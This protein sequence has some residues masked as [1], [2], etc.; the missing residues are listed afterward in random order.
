MT[1]RRL[2]SK[3]WS[4][5]SQMTRLPRQAGGHNIE[6]YHLKHK[7]HFYNLLRLLVSLTYEERLLTR[8]IT[9]FEPRTQKISE[10]ENGTGSRS[11]MVFILSARLCT[12]S[13]IDLTNYICSSTTCQDW[14]SV[15]RTPDYS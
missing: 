10:L 6:S 2:R 14:R 12:E 9:G 5:L 8:E 13:A 7:L 3:S 1:P 4:S 11:C 15:V